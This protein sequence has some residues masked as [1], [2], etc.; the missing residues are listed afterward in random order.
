MYKQRR[1][2][3]KYLSFLSAN[4]AIHYYVLLFSGKDHSSEYLSQLVLMKT[5]IAYYRGMR[6][7]PPLSP[8]LFCPHWSGSV[9]FNLFK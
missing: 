2:K 9:F 6:D 5:D 8:F 3:G 1:N 7:P 4:I